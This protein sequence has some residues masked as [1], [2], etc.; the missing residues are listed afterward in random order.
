MSGVAQLRVPYATDTYEGT[1][2]LGP[3]RV[4]I[5]DD[6]PLTLEVRD[7]DVRSGASIELTPPGGAGLNRR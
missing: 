4:V 6:A 3:Y 2:A 5:G 1:R 7:E